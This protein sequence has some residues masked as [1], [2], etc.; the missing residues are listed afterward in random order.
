MPFSP[1]RQKTRRRERCERIKLYELA[2][3][4]RT[5]RVD[6]NDRIRQNR[7]TRR[8]KQPERMIAKRRGERRDIV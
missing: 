8:G 4:A 2:Q 7:N 3:L 5:L 1:G 6:A